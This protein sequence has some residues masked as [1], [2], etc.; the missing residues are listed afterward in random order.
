M[1]KL[2]PTALVAVR[3]NSRFVGPAGTVKL[4]DRVLPPCRSTVGPAI[5]VQRNVVPS[6]TE[7]VIVIVPPALALDG[8]SILRPVD[9]TGAS[10]VV[11]SRSVDL[12]TLALLS[13]TMNCG[14]ME[15][16]SA[17]LTPS[18]LL[19]RSAALSLCTAG[20][21][22]SPDPLLVVVA[23]SAST[24]GFAVLEVETLGAETLCVGTFDA[25]GVCTV[26]FGTTTFGL[27]TTGTAT[28]D[29]LAPGAVVFGAVAL[30]V[31]T[32]ELVTLGA[33]ILCVV[34]FDAAGGCRIGF[35]TAT[36][37]LDTTGTATVDMLAPGAVVFGVVTIGAIVLVAGVPV[38]AAPGTDALEFFIFVSM[39]VLGGNFVP[40]LFVAFV[41]AVRP[42]QSDA[43]DQSGRAKLGRPAIVL[44]SSLR[45]HFSVGRPMAPTAGNRRYKSSAMPS[46][47]LSLTLFSLPTCP[48]CNDSDG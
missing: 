3:R 38:A 10:V 7:P 44:P 14:D 20:S 30:G 15:V 37:G 13:S 40:L 12:D 46:R 29:M 27:D 25:A 4:G 18:V 36:F 23:P 1:V 32:L 28:V 21:T 2:A 47:L 35:G 39:R 48:S 8:A 31:D 6:D 41:V 26:G 33:E 17:G 11:N 42:G 24:P 45:K 43:I 5:C 19:F 9:A 34:T 16:R 22:L